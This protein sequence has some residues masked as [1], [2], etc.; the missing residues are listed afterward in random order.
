MTDILHTVDINK[1]SREEFNDDPNGR[2]L[3]WEWPK[4]GPEYVIG[5]DVSTGVGL[6]NSVAHILKVGSIYE[7]YEQVAEFACNFLDPHDLVPV[8]N[9]VG[10]LYW[11]IG[12]GQ[13]ALMCIECNNAGESTQ[14]DLMTQHNY[15]NLFIWKVYDRAGNVLTNRL[16]WWTTPRTRRKIVLHGARLL[17]SG[18]WKINSPWFIDEMA[19]FEL[20]RGVGSQ[21]LDSEMEAIARHKSGALDDRL[22]AGFIAVWCAQ[23]LR[24]AG[25]ENPVAVHQQ[26]KERQE[27]REKALRVGRPEKDYQNTAISY[28]KMKESEW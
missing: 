3:I 28:E 11:C 27:E 24:E 12:S 25:F 15:S 4:I 26:W 19:D 10:R 20:Q 18:G 22:M 23:D 5:V 6:T 14:Y 21:M 1:L 2:L 8:L 13:P 7:P 16:G 9:T 17:R